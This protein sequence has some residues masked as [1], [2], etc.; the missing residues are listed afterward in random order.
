MIIVV[1]MY[2]YCLAGTRNVVFVGTR[3]VYR[4]SHADTVYCLQVYVIL[5]S[6]RTSYST[7]HADTV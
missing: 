5:A 1:Y 7:F 2:A 3:I 4:V 6:T